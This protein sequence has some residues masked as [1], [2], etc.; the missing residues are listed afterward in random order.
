MPAATDVLYHLDAAR[1]E[2]QRSYMRELE[3]AGVCV[4]CPEHF[5]AHHREPIALAGR[6]WY[7][8]QNDYPYEGA[9]AHYL[10]VPHLHVASFDELPDEAGAELWALKRELKL[11]L[12]PLATAT[13][14]RSGDMHYNGGSVA[15]LHVHFVALDASPSRTV[16]FRVSRECDDAHA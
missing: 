12:S 16:R 8:T 4:F 11:L 2:A 13:V 14:E 3:A 1:S 10:I 15:H 6:H 9:A 7:V 5:A